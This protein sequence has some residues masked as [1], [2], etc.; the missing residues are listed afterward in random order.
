MTGTQYE[1]LCRFFLADKLEIPIKEVLSVKIPNPKRP[2]LPEYNHQIDLYW[3]DGN[4]LTQY[5]NIANAKWR[6]SGKVEQGEVLLLQ[7]VKEKVFANKS[8]MITNTGF[9]KG[10]K[11]VAQDEG[12]A[13]HIVC[14]SFDRSILSSGL[15]DR[16]MFQTQLQ[17]LSSNSKVVYSHTTVHR[18]FELETSTEVQSSAPVKEVVSPNRMNRMA[19]PPSTRI[20]PPNT[21]TTSGG[22]GRSHGGFAGN[23]RGG[24]NRGR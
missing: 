24:A 2:D 15:K 20:T 22:H 8:M 17:K 19:Q 1:E 16:E 3:E 14:P 18:A 12:V 6:S 9:T 21:K 11:A 13:L 10:A 7:K 23:T 5:L 4:Q